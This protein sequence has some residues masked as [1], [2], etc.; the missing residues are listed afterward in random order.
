MRREGRY[1]LW[2]E[3]DVDDRLWLPLIRFIARA[4]DNGVAP[5][6]V[7][8]LDYRD[9]MLM[10]GVE[11]R[12]RPFLYVYKHVDSRRHVCVDEEGTPY[13]LVAGGT[14]GR[15]LVSLFTRAVWQLDP[16][17]IRE[18]RRQFGDGQE[19]ECLDDDTRWGEQPT[20]AAPPP[21]GPRHLQI[22]R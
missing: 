14:D 12:P 2:D 15:Y 8:E 1:V 22:V 20:P 21:A 11:R 9:F 10:N 3:E 19:L 7:F 13:R 18:A 5:W 6:A 16:I 4:K 17:F